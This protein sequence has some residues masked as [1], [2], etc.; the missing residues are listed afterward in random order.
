[1]QTAQAIFGRENGKKGIVFTITSWCLTL[2]DAY[3]NSAESI[4]T[5]CIIAFKLFLT[6]LFFLL[7]EQCFAIEAF[8]VISELIL[9]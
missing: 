5:M 3:A 8:S 1:M 7:S 4:P 6:F 9:L 2:D